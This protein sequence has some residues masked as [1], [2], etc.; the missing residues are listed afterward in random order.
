MWNLI[1]PANAI[2][3]FKEKLRGI[4]TIS[5]GG[6]TSDETLR[7][8]ARSDAYPPTVSKSN[9]L[10]AVFLS[11]ETIFQASGD[12]VPFENFFLISCVRNLGSS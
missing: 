11:I 6:S 9:R 3:L 8:F 7:T 2:F 12:S 4:S 1:L 10:F 5:L